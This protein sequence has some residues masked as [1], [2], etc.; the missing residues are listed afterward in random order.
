MDHRISRRRLHPFHTKRNQENENNIENNA[1]VGVYHE[2]GKRS[3]IERKQTPSNVNKH[4]TARHLR[5]WGAL[6]RYV[7]CYPVSPRL[8][9]VRM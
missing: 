5:F 6:A 9:V 4:V 8:Q 1:R 2:I 7:K 3:V